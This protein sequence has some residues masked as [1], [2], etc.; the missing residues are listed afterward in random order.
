[1]GF[2]IQPGFSMDSINKIVNDWTGNIQKVILT[3]FKYIGEAFVKNAR[4][5]GDYL[6]QTGNLRSS[7]G[8]IIVYNG[9]IVETNFK[10]AGK[11]T[12]K[13]TGVAK[14]QEYAQEIAGEH[15]RGY[16]LICVAGMEYAAIVESRGRDVISNS[17]IN[18]KR[19]LEKAIASLDKKLGKV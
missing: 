5:S 9:N 2:T 12:D 14:A 8:Y 7:I 6:D 10:Q 1:M 11:G 18:A 3:Q 15:P 16:V 4:D 13:S 19:D 17:A